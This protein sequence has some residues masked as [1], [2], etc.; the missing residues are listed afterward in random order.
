MPTRKVVR[1][2][3]RLLWE[4]EDTASLEV[5]KPQPG[6]ATLTCS[7]AGH[8]LA[9]GWDGLSDPQGPSEQHYN[10]A[11]SCTCPLNTHLV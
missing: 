8:S 1:P 5:S 9:S 4:L 2:G 11:K 10:T 6:K 3:N 7:S